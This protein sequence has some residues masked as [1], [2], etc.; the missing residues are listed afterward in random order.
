MLLSSLLHN[1]EGTALCV[2]ISLSLF[3][4]VNNNEVVPVNAALLKLFS[5]MTL[6]RNITMCVSIGLFCHGQRHRVMLL[7]HSTDDTDGETETI[8]NQVRKQKASF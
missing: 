8:F 1:S 6:V 4:K 2:I 7:T 3:P 5:R